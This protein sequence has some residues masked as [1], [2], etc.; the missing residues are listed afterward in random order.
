MP[1]AAA[2][3]WITAAAAGTTAGAAVYGA[4]K[5]GKGIDAQTRLAEE[6]FARSKPAF[7]ASFGYYNNLLSGDKGALAKAVGPEVNANNMAFQNAQRS[8]VNN[9]LTGRGGGLT[10]RLGQLK[11]QQAMNISNLIGGARNNAAAQLGNLANGNQLA[12]LEAM[13]AAQ[14]QRYL[15]SEQNSA[16]WGQVGSFITRLLQDPS[17]F[18]SNFNQ[19]QIVPQGFSPGANQFDIN[20]FNPGPSVPRAEVGMTTGTPAWGAR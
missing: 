13:A 20:R 15:G 5:A 9:P 16:A 6:N 2:I 7:D 14:R 3:P 17:L 18:G 10:S 19:Q 12:G 11:G 4:R 1:V 8:L